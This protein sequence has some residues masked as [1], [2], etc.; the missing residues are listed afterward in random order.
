ML[1]DRKTLVL[2]V[3]VVLV[4]VVAVFFVQRN[5]SQAGSTAAALSG[6]YGTGGATGRAG[7]SGASIAEF[8][9]RIRV[10]EDIVFARSHGPG[11]ARQG[12][13]LS[14]AHG[15]S[16]ALPG[17]QD[18]VTA[19]LEAA[20]KSQAEFDAEAGTR[21]SKGAAAETKV[22]SA[23]KAVVAAE[24]RYA[25]MESRQPECRKTMCRMQ[26]SYADHST[27][28]FASTM[29]LME[30]NQTFGKSDILILPSDDGRYDLLVFSH[31]R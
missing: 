6:P 8:E 17:T 9:Q 16:A 20:M 27:A 12:D 4:L 31:L 23:V 3:A 1:Q 29:L 24:Q 21:S 22:A 28:E 15:R 2:A 18:A 25:P 11:R 13:R 7:E 19:T 30:L 5:A 10:L 26:Y 14:D